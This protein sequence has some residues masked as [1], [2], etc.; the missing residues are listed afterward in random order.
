[1]GDQKSA[2][3]IGNIIELF[4]NA[5]LDKS[6][7]SASASAS[8]SSRRGLTTNAT[9]ARG[10]LSKTAKGKVDSTVT[11]DG[12][13]SDTDETIV[14]GVDRNGTIIA[15]VKNLH[16]C[17]GVQVSRCDIQVECNKRA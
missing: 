9:P 15:G 17:G 6:Y 2:I 16:N 14:S 1:M 10:L 7:P 3:T 8:A 12:V 5:N 4:S 13:S 11:S